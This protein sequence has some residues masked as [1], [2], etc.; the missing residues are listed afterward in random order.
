MLTISLNSEKKALE[1]FNIC[2]IPVIAEDTGLFVKDLDNLPGVF[3]KR[4]LDGSDNDRNLAIINNLNKI[5]N[6][7]RA[8]SYKSSFSYY[9]GIKMITVE[10][11][12]NGTIDTKI[13][14]QNGFAY[15]SIFIHSSGKKISEMSLSEKNKISQRNDALKKLKEKFQ[16]EI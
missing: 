9:D 16:K 12:C 7:S 1:Y 4:W 11:V 13:S 6:S 8:A 10:G 14:G 15:D 5:P 2:K 3:S